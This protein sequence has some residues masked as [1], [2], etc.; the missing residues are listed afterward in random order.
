MIKKPFTT[1]EIDVIYKELYDINNRIA[2]ILT[3]LDDKYTRT[4]IA[5]KQQEIK[6]GRCESS[7]E[8][9]EHTVDAIIKK[10]FLMVKYMKHI[11]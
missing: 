5:E 3:V 1:E 8:N 10:Y 7:A 9:L 6:S 11:V 4:L 2:K